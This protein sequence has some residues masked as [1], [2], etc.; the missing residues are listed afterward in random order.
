MEGFLSS[1]RRLSFPPMK[2]TFDQI[3][4]N[5]ARCPFFY[6]WAILF[7]GIIGIIL[8]VPGQTTG[9]S[10]FIEPLIHDLGIGRFQLTIAYGIGTF[11]S[12]FLITPSGK[13]FDR[14]GARWMGFGSCMILGL[15]LLALSQTARLARIAEPLL[16][17]QTG[18]VALLSLLF[19][20]LRLSG[21]GVLTMSSR[22]MVMKWFDHHR[23]LAS[24]ISGAAVAFSFSYA[25]TI[26]SGMI[27]ERGWA[28]TWLL[29][30]LLLMLFFS[31][32][33][34]TF[35]RDSPEPLGLIPD[36]QKQ[37]SG[38]Q[39]ESPAASSHSPKPGAP[40]P[41]GPSP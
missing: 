32:L 2:K 19:F 21:Q 31:P 20:A 16:P 11:A 29:L 41:S 34:L 39:S 35:F 26:F 5:P 7:W 25:P 40:C 1:G 37:T 36:G 6:G 8:S 14:I 22:N 30:G 23:G 17:G 3:P 13:L 18:L 38:E 27:N 12:S 10:A 33:L 24:G 4:F 28:A 9:V 15:V